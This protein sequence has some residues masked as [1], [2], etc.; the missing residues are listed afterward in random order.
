MVVW[1]GFDIDECRI[2]DGKLVLDAPFMLWQN[3]EFEY[4]VGISADDPFERSLD[5]WEG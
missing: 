2:E 1:N 3:S 4:F 5:I